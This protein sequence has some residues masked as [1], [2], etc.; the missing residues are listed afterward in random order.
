MTIGT[1]VFA[2]EM[3]STKHA[4]ASLALDQAV[5]FMASLS[6]HFSRAEAEHTAIAS[7]L[8]SLLEIHAHVVNGH[9]VLGRVYSAD[10]RMI[11]EEQVPGGSPLPPPLTVHERTSAG[12]G[13]HDLLFS[14]RNL[15]V[16]I[17]TPIPRVPDGYGGLFQ[18]IYRVDQATLFR[19]AGHAL[20]T[21]AICMA[22]VVAHTGFLYPALAALNRQL[23]DLSGDLL[24]A[25]ISM[26]ET[27]GTAV[28]MRDGDT[29]AHNHRVTLYAAGLGEAVDLPSCEMRA[30]IKGAFLHDV[31]KIGV[32]DAILLKPARLTPGEF[33]LIRSHVTQE[34][35]VV[36][37]SKWLSDAEVVVGGHHEKW[38]GSGYPLG[39]RG[40]D[41]PLLARIFSIAD[42]FDAL[43]SQRPY[44]PA[45]LFEEAWDILK[46]GRGVHFDPELLDRFYG[47]SGEIYERLAHSRQSDL[48]AMLKT[49]V[50]KYFC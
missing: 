50:Q 6:V 15:Y 36:R 8:R 14:D 11:A 45:L 7:G 33:D 38:D 26:L 21:V 4:I 47:I 13:R 43:S 32:S 30:L 3:R 18:A 39:S 37:Q 19:L 23:I 28:A 1:V 17:L 2:F 42:V 48:K 25:N 22:V 5:S 12:S 40:N 9:F 10:G 29:G 31:G 46:R 34:L 27:L 16:S 20:L 24:D 35:Y 49:V 44:K 41:I